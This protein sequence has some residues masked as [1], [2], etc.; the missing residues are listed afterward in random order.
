MR[1]RS[2]STVR[3]TGPSRTGKL[4]SR[5][6]ASIGRRSKPRRIAS[7]SATR[8]RSVSYDT[9]SNPV[10]IV[11]KLLD[12]VLVVLPFGEKEQKRFVD[13]MNEALRGVH[14]VAARQCH[15]KRHVSPPAPARDAGPGRV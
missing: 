2:S 5:W 1:T 9:L 12:A 4:S 10:W 11:A 8:R 6:R 7:R 14:V 3:S 15:D 13:Q